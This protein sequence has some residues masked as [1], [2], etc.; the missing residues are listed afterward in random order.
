MGARHPT[1]HGYVSSAIGPA[2]TK[3]AG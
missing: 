3:R 2:R 1:G